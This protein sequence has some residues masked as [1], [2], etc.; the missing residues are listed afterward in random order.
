MTN[1]SKADRGAMQ[2]AMLR[3]FNIRKEY[4]KAPAIVEWMHSAPVAL[5]EYEGYLPNEKPKHRDRR[6]EIHSV[7]HGNIKG[8]VDH[9]RNLDKSPEARSSWREILFTYYKG[10]SDVQEVIARAKTQTA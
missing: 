4:L 3:T 8:L 10:I 1:Y 2:A 9:L 5:V 7:Y 6:M